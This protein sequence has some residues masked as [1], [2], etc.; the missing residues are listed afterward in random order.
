MRTIFLRALCALAACLALVAHAA[1]ITGG[2]RFVFYSSADG[3]SVNV[4]NTSADRYLVQSKITGED[5]PAPFVVTP[6]LFMLKGGRENT[7]RILYTGEPLPADRESLFWLT[8]AGIPSTPST[9]NNNNVE[10]ALRQRMKLFWRP[11]A[12][13]GKAGE[14][15][16]HLTWTRTGEQVV[17]TN[18]TPWFVT[19]IRLTSN[20]QAIPDAG[21]VA[22]FSSRTERWCPVQG[23]CVMKWQTLNDY[24]SLLP[25]VSAVPREGAR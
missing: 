19:L 7:L 20:G 12:L 23:P 2:T 4:R 15:Y 16:R 18:P 10:V 6:P 25:A 13:K 14:A 5:R 11:A 21:M 17:V 8:V 9:G 22:P 1:I 24:G 3:L